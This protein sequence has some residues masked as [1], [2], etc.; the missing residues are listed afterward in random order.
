MLTISEKAQA[1]LVGSRAKKQARAAW[2][3]GVAALSIL[4]TGCASTP[5][6]KP[7]RVGG[8]QVRKNDDVRDV[9]RVPATNVY[10]PP[11]MTGRPIVR[12][13]L[14]APFSSPNAGLRN[15]AQTLQSAAELAIA[16][17]GDNSM[18]L[19]AKDSGDSPEE[20]RI[21][22]RAALSEGANFVLGPLFAS[23]VGAVAPYARANNAPMISFSTDT[24][25]AG[26][27]VYVLTF[28]PEDE[29]QRIVRFAASR[30]VKR[31]VVLAPT[32]RYGDRIND[33]AKEAA[34]EVG[35]DYQGAARYDG[36]AGTLAAVQEG[37]KRAAQLASGGA[38]RDTAI[39]IPERGAMLRALAQSL[40]QAGAPASRVRYLGTGLWNDSETIADPRLAG[41][42]YVT[43]DSA[44]RTAFEQRFSA[45]YGRKPTRLAGMA[46]DATAMLA[47]MTRGGNAIA[48][49]PRAIEARDGFVGVDGLFRFSRGV[50]QRGMA[51]NEVGPR[52]GKTVDPA[53]A[54]FSQ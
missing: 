36:Q 25:E 6:G 53:P 24:S 18:L 45:K 33:A 22:V 40:S 19:I 16:E 11:G 1:C 23:G 26:R 20:A 46:Y 37:A 47:G 10:T 49:S 12:V 13:A 30:G 14:L 21:A 39:L 5:S 4:V 17:R 38:A 35:L 28:L 51:V 7:D 31:L 27:G 43:P 34:R 2:W 54:S 32:G 48:A 29:A 9:F 42:W 3:A 44:A 15:E 50:V 41:G 52:G 8:P